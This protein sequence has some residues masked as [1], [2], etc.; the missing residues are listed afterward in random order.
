MKVTKKQISKY[1]S[2]LGRLGGLSSALSKGNI[3]LDEYKARANRARIGNRS[4]LTE[5]GST[6]SQ[7]Y[8]LTSKH[9]RIT[10]GQPASML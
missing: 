9:V 10:N 5:Q 8:P 6:S 7:A 1:A 2:D 4:S 3:S